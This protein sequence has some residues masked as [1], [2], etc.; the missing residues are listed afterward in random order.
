MNFN[1]DGDDLFATN[2]D[3]DGDPTSSWAN[4][5]NSQQVPDFDFSSLTFDEDI[6]SDS[7]SLS[8]S[9]QSASNF[10]TD[11]MNYFPPNQSQGVSPIDSAPPNYMRQNFQTAPQ[12]RFNS[13]HRGVGFSPQPPM[14]MMRPFPISVSGRIE[15][16]AMDKFQA[17]PKKRKIVPWISST[18]TAIRNDQLFNDMILNPSISLNPVMCGFIPSFFWPNREIPF[19]DLVYDFFQLKNNINCRFLHKLYN[20]L[21]VS[22]VSEYYATIVG[23]RWITPNV[24]M[25]FKGEFARLLGI[26]SIDGSLF[27]QQGN[28]PTHGFIELNQQQAQII[29]QGI[30]ISM[31]DYENVRLLM[32]QPGLFTANCTEAQ[33]VACRSLITHRK[34]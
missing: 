31:V 16:A 12:R 4:S 26:K 1:P 20:A 34:K 9:V 27:H 15:L 30:D 33:L 32:H 25:V 17:R 10:K 14:M 11:P 2:D 6:F 3:G 22:T 18:E 28:F 24:I 7:S 5:N 29:C 13:T 19:V 21:R 23:V 8:S